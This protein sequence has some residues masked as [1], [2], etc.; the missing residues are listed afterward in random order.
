VT[1]RLLADFDAN[2]IFTIAEGQLLAAA[3]HMA[4]IHLH[5]SPT[6]SNVTCGTTMNGYC[7]SDPSNA[8]CVDP[9]VQ[10]NNVCSDVSAVVRV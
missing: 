4:E 3:G 9:E 10:L 2:G 8:V 7:P 5:V 1:D 6:S